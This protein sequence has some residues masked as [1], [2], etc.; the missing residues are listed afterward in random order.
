MHKPYFN[1]QSTKIN[2]PQ[3]HLKSI[4]NRVRNTIT[5][6]INNGVVLITADEEVE[7]SSESMMNDE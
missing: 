1:I 7:E 5:T 6:E 2:H 4:N 3:Q